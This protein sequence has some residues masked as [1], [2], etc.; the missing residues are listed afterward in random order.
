MNRKDCRGTCAPRGTSA[1]CETGGAVLGG[2]DDIH[3]YA[4]EAEYSGGFDEGGEIAC[5]RLKGQG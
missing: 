2:R 1:G 4:A 5:C 3:G